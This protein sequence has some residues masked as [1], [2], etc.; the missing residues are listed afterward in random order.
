MILKEGFESRLSRLSGA[1]NAGSSASP[2]GSNDGGGDMK[3]N[4]AC[5]S[6]QSNGD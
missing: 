6:S 3:F 4:M 5:V 1:P 2:A